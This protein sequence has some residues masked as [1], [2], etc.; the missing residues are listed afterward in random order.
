[1]KVL[2]YLAAFIFIIVLGVV[3]GY[4]YLGGFQSVEVTH[5]SFAPTEIVFSTHKG[6]YMKLHESW[7][8]F[9]KDLVA[10]GLQECDAMAVYLD[11]PGTPEDQLRSVIACRLD[12]LNVDLKTALKSK[13]KSF[14]IPSSPALTAKFPY[15]NP[16]SFFVGP[17]KVY[18]AMKPLIAQESKLPAVAYEVYGLEK[19]TTEI[20][21]AMPLGL[22]RAVF[23]PLEAAFQ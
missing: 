3:A 9:R 10:A 12:G 23:Q 8:K 17:G 13:L 6:P 21:Y 5:G 19:T 1:M 14:Q 15:K 4:A 11:P 7:D 2:K 20:L 22:D 16:F 18:P